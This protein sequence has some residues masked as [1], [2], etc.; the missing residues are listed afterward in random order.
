MIKI[1]KGQDET[2]DENG[3]QNYIDDA[4]L[5]DKFDVEQLNNEINK[6]YTIKVKYWLIIDN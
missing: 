6:N 3:P 1:T 2:S 4:I 5:I